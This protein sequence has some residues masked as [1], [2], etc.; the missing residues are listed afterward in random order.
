[1]ISSS[2]DATR[3]VKKLIHGL[4]DGVET[5]AKRLLTERICIGITGLSKS[6]KSTFLTSLINQLKQHRHAR[7]SAF[8]PWLKEQ[9]ISVNELPLEDRYLPQ[10]SYQSNLQR[11]IS[12]PPEWPASTTDI[13]G[14]LLEIKL[15][16]K[17]LLRSTR[18]VYVELR[19]YPGEWLLDLPLLHL[20]F[21]EWCD[22]Q[23]KLLSAD[24]RLKIDPDF[25]S[26]L[27]TLD[28]QTIL[29]GSVIDQ[30]GG[31]YADFLL[32]CKN[33]P[34]GPISLIQPGRFLLSGQGATPPLFFPLTSIHEADFNPKSC[35]KESLYKE[36]E[37][38]FEHYKKEFVL[39]FFRQFI[40]PIDRQIVLVDV[41]QALNGGPAQLRDLREAIGAV[42][43]SFTYGAGSFWKSKIEKVMFVATKVDQV[44]AKDHDN[45][46]QL[47]GSVVKSA[48]EHA[49]HNDAEYKV[50][51]I[52]SVRSAQDIKVKGQEGMT[53]SSLQGEAI[54][55]VHP[56]I[57]NHIPSDLESA[58][59]K[60]WKLPCLVP[61]AG[62][63][64]DQD[65]S[66]PHIRLDQ[67][68]QD[69][70]GDICK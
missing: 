21:A 30:I 53:G 34:D 42:S 66:L 29:A 45:V 47:L 13:S 55:Y 31:D 17:R 25:C 65:H 10:F 63:R 19:D 27:E 18:V 32:K 56:E 35:S 15:R 11:L 57:P 24:L 51:A 49:S 20:T 62:V 7:L 4:Q 67:V 46:R 44:I 50:E 64:A 2:D 38:R 22:Q 60:A 33:A 58:P 40:Q 36:L 6:G 5:S 41:L 43:E 28:P 9:I 1:M 48:L 26:R 52:A 37:Q 69:L 54:A 12:A 70:L 16:S 68:M 61:P 14:V 59:F 23:S 3:K 8:S 39:P